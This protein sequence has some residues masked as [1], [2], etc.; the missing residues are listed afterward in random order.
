MGILSCSTFEKHPGKL[1]VAR[2]YYHALDQSNY[3][4]IKD[5]IS[6]SITTKEVNYERILTRSQFHEF[7]KWDSIFEPTYKVLKLD[8]VDGLITATVSK[9]DKR[10]LFLHKAPIITQEV[11]RFTEGRIASVEITDYISFDDKIFAEKRDSLL[12]WVDEHHPELN[13][14]IQDQTEFGAKNYLKAIE[15]YN[16]NSK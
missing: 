2:K 7:M 13:G 12:T 6:D 5:L 1:Q 4:Q 10:I 14:F 11:L 16:N 3:L 8:Q 9:L 15:L